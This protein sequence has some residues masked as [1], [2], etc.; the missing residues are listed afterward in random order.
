[1]F[2]KPSI[3]KPPSFA[4]VAKAGKADAEAAIAAARRSFDSGVWSNLSPAAR[5]DNI[6]DFADQVG[7]QTLRMAITES[8]DAGHVIKLAKFWAMLGMGMLRNLGYYASREFPWQ[9]EI[10]YS[11]NVFAPGREWIRREPLGVC[12]GIVPWN[13]PMYIAIWKIAPPF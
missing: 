8:Q 12:V 5:A 10:P 6:Y 2:L 3:R 13:F 1:M 9:E 11:G 7:Q 4:T